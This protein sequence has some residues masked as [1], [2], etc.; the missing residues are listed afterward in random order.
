MI[1]LRFQLLLASL[2]IQIDAFTVLQGHK[3]RYGSSLL[4]ASN[5]GT[6][7]F[8]IVTSTCRGTY[9]C[10]GS[11]Y[12]ITSACGEIIRNSSTRRF[13][14]ESNKID[15]VINGA[16][17]EADNIS[18]SNNVSIED[19]GTP[20][21]G[22]GVEGENSIVMGQEEEQSE[23]DDDDAKVNTDEGYA[24]LKEASESNNWEGGLQVPIVEEFSPSSTTT[25]K[26]DLLA[27]QSQ[28]V[29]TMEYSS[30]EKGTEQKVN[31]S[32]HFDSSPPLTFSKYLT[33]QE[34]RVPIVIRYSELQ[35]LRSYYLTTAKKIKDSNPDVTVEKRI[36]PRNEE[37]KD[38]DT[39]FEVLVDNRIVVGKGQCK[40]QGVTRSASGKDNDNKINQVFGMSVYISMQDINEAIAKARRKRRPSTTYAQHGMVMRRVGLEILKGDDMTRGPIESNG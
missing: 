17:E 16:G 34:K 40:W 31:L 21:E 25:T 20:N 28:S 2:I 5:D 19:E 18:R 23:V 37:H 10:S 7:P 32:E 8:P 39:V 38:E 9:T 33:M 1:H 13:V 4:V 36:I 35:G 24:H 15:E 6:N 30:E 14:K 29:N 22:T 3:L 27:D 11:S 26:E 12:K